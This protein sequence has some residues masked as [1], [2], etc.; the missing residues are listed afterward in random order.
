MKNRILTNLGILFIGTVI[1]L[2]LSKCSKE[3]IIVCGIENVC[4]DVEDLSWFD[5]EVENQGELY[6][7]YFYV[8]QAIYEGEVVFLFENCCPNCAT[9]VPVKNCAGE[10]L[11]HLGYDQG[12][13]HPDEISDS[14]VIWKA[15]ENQCVFID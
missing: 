6:N 10:T 9:I 12:A 13:I 3:E 1:I 5:E 15:P 7:K 8:S 2:L 11:G 4:G 14:F